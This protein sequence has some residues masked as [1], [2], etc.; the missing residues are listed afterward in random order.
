MVKNASWC[1]N[2]YNQYTVLVDNRENVINKLKN[3]GIETGIM[4]PIGCH[5]QPS[6]N[7]SDMLKSTD[8][9]TKRIL[10]LPCWPYMQ[11]N[12]ISYVIENFNKII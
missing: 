4:W 7:S 2:V 1:S 10:S 5:T 9:V 3:Q 8:Y 12:E 6:Y 11:D